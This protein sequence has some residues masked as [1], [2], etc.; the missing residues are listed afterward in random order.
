MIFPFSHPLRIQILHT[1]K[2]GSKRFTSLKNELNVKNTGLLV[3]HLK[4]LTD[5][6][7]VFQDHRKQYSLS[8]KGFIVVRYFAQL[9]A[10]MHPE[11]PITISMQPLVVLQ[12]DD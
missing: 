6:N 12:D 4:P 5:C 10:A 9:V 11:T 8:E 7:L 1:L 3:H 2:S